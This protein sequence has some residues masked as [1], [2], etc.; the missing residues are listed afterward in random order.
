MANLA[1]IGA[2]I[3]GC[4][5][6]YFARKY[7]SDTNVTIYESQ[8][9]IGGRI[10]THN[11]AGVNL[12]LGATFFNGFNKTL[13]SIIRAE[14]LRI[15]PVE[16]MDFAVW[17]GSGLV[18]R[19][20]KK[21][22]A[23]S[24]KLLAKYNLSVARALVLVRKAKAQISKLYEEER[25]NPGDIGKIFEATGLDKW[26]K[27]ALSKILGDSSV[28][29][30]FIDEIVTPITR[31]I[32]SQNADIGGLAGIS[33]LI[34]VYSGAT[35]NLAEGN[36]TLPIHLAEASNATVELGQKVDK[37]EKMPGGAYRVCTGKDRGI[38]DSVIVA[39]PLD[40][41]DIEFDG[42]SAPGW[43]PQPYQSVYRKVMRGILDSNYFSLGNSAN[44]P[45]IVLTTK[46]AGPITHYGI[47]KASGGESLVTISSPEPLNH[48]VFDGV[49]KNDGVTVL[50]HC[51]KTAYPVFKPIAELP[52]TR[53]DKRLM[54][55]S[56]I[57]PSISSMETSALS[58]LN[59][60]RM[61][62]QEMTKH[63]SQD[64][65]R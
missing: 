31:I 15:A 20:S 32:Y 37:I 30:A 46:D 64:S 14:H 44:P 19:S 7:L 26:H 63:G 9:R 23:T 25:R 57:E 59:A 8:D 49:F 51:W 52:L 13:L 61:L 35:Y 47:Q 40:L 41:A 43:N 55:V 3:S 28:G 42:L 4:S 33:S 17:N 16:R 56:A 36:I 24:T 65:S 38:F 58:A 11:A 60:A 12:E 34:G 1:V 2:G 21:P 50:E 29:Q 48:N 54:Y 18:F 39:A 5:A 62:R 10:L 45:A 27:K 53:I 6:A 22:F